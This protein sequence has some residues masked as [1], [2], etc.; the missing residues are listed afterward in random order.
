MVCTCEA[1]ALLDP[2][3][4]SGVVSPGCV[5]GRTRVIEDESHFVLCGLLLN[6]SSVHLPFP[7]LHLLEKEITYVASST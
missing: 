6:G 5:W 3:C 2:A 1:A 4:C 7:F